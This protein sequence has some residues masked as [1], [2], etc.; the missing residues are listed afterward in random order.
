[1]DIQ[2][3]SIGLAGMTICSDSNGDGYGKANTRPLRRRR[4][5][6]VRVKCDALRRRKDRDSRRR[7]ALA[8]AAAEEEISAEEEF[9]EENQIPFF[10]LIWEK[11]FVFFMSLPSIGPMRYTSEPNVRDGMR[12]QTLQIFSIRV[13]DP[14]DGLEW[15]LNVYGYVAARDTIDHNRNYLFRRERDNFQTL[16]QEDPF[17]LLTGPSRA[18]VLVDPIFF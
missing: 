1:M 7:E 5:R 6:V 8:G 2:M 3:E 10:F 17:L 14:T 4:G 16:T 12:E 18:V 9:K 15:P 11:Y 13:T